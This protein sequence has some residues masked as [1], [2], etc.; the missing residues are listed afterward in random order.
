MSQPITLPGQSQVG[1]HL[2]DQ[3][4]AI[5][6]EVT[7]P[8]DTAVDHIAAAAENIAAH[9]PDWFQLA[10][11]Q[12][13]TAQDQPTTLPGQSQAGEHLPE[14]LPAIPL[15]V[16]LPNDTAVEHIAAAAENIAAHIPDWFLL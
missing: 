9:I 7:L 5:P 14:Q 15:E 12:T 1:E 13:V 2:P 4:P 11:A 8:N 3:L 10:S 6:S 16:T